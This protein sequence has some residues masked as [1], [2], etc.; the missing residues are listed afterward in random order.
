MLK[1]QYYNAWWCIRTPINLES[2]MRFVCHKGNH[3]SSRHHHG[4][5]SCLSTI[6]RPKRPEW[7]AQGWGSVRGR[8]GTPSCCVLTGLR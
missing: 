7:L 8:G 5:A 2:P 6:S 3:F 1:K 4:E